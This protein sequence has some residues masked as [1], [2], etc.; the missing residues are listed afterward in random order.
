MAELYSRPNS[1]IDFGKQESTVTYTGNQEFD[2]VLDSL[3]D[4]QRQ[5]ALEQYNSPLTGE[6]VSQALMQNPKWK[7]TTDEYKAYKEYQG[8]KSTDIFDAIGMAAGA[9]VDDFSRAFQ[10]VGESPLTNTAKLPLSLVEAFAQGT[11]NL[12][13]MMSQSQDP[14]SVMFKW[15]DALS[16]QYSDEGYRQFLEAREFNSHSIDLATGKSTLMVDKDLVNH[17]VVQAASYIAD[18]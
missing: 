11:R 18:P 6:E 12:Y 15:K 10:A 2:S 1:N 13:G 8:T 16:N 3:P 14:N 17:D 9:V 4:D 5:K 7:P